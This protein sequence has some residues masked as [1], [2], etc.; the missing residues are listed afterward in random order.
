MK[1]FGVDLSLVAR[2]ASAGS[3]PA[4]GGSQ[5]LRSASHGGGSDAD[6]LEPLNFRG[7]SGQ[8]RRRPQGLPPR[9]QLGAR[10]TARGYVACRVAP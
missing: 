10:M 1:F 4:F 3:L 8:R 7:V 5:R 6:M 2:T 9:L